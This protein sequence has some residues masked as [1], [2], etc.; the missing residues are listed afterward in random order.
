MKVLG[1]VA[2]AV[3]MTVSAVAAVKAPA[4]GFR[5]VPWNGSRDDF[6]K[7]IP[8]LTCAPLACHG[9]IEV[10]DIPTKVELTW[11][12]GGPN[13]SILSL[14][15]SRSHVTEMKRILIQKYGAPTRR[16]SEDGVMYT[17]WKL[18]DV[19][20]QLD[21]GQSNENRVISF[22]VNAVYKKFAEDDRAEKLKREAAHKKATRGASKSW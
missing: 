8:G 9:E 11:G 14:E 13:L 21:P 3:T 2:M 22:A 1:I 18:P 4:G 10:G 16:Y 17:E 7:A 12:R 5:G 15:F 6:K 20:V 19:T